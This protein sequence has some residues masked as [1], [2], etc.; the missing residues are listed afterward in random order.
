MANNIKMFKQQVVT[1]C[2]YLDTINRTALDFD[3]EPTCSLTL[4]SGPHIYACLVCGKFFRGKGKQTPAYLHC[5][6]ENHNVFLHLQKGTFWCLPDD[7]EIVDPSLDDI[8]SAFKPIYSKS[9]IEMMDRQTSL[10]RDLFGKRYLPG[11]V[12]LNNLNKTDCINATLQAL[13]HVKP[14]RDFFLRCGSEKPFEITLRLPRLSSTSSSSSSSTSSSS[15]AKKRKREDS[16]IA[17]DNKS[18]IKTKKKERTIKSYFKTKKVTIDPTTFSHLAKVFGDMIRK[19][20]S[21]HRF[22]STVDPHMFIQAVST[23]SNKRFT[24]GKQIDAG[25]F[26]RWLLFQL[27]IGI[28]GSARSSNGKKSGSS[29]IHDIFHGVV[30]ITTRQLVHN[31]NTDIDG[32]DEDDRYGSED[33]EEVRAREEEK[34]RRLLEEANTMEEITTSTNFLQLTL[35]IPE[36]PLFKDETHG[37]LV[38]PQEPLVNILQKFDG[39]SFYDVLLANNNNDSIRGLQKRRYRL[40]QLPKYLILCLARFKR[41]NFTIEKNPTIVPF[42]VKNLDLGSYVY[43]EDENDDENGNDEESKSKSKAKS[44]VQFPTEE[45]IKSMK[46]KELKELLR[47][48]DGLDLLQPSSSSKSIIEKQELVDVCINYFSKSLPQ[49]LS[50]KYDLVANITHTIPAEVGREGQF[51]PL[52]E[53]EYKCHVHHEATSQWYD[54]QD[55]HVQEIM[56]Q[57]I[58]LSESF[59]LIFEQK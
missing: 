20:W 5:I 30:D 53:G 43:H 50:N 35:D 2:P 26:M 17:N 33:E 46:V 34:Q 6:N 8:K 16:S 42:P 37:G 36:K 14:L 21:N 7:Y 1:S 11:F 52:Q 39:V 32:E 47:K 56:P 54:I 31:R 23:A 12:G 24:I 55:L 15:N 40:R 59:V 9:E 48:N 58:G 38:I 18:T 57:L 41:N 29:I 19:M 4:S 22:K 27:H 45:E 3:F 13:A 49:L 10:S 44:K 51:D 25:E 28:G